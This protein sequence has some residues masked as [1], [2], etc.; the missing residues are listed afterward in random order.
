M[1]IPSP[2]HKP[3]LTIRRAGE[4][5][6]PDIVRIERA[7]FPTPWS[8]WALRAE[9]TDTRRHLYLVVTQGSTAISYVGG[10]WFL[11]TCHIS[12]LA[13]DETLRS[14][15]LGEGMMLVLLLHL[16]ENGARHATL[17]Y[18]P[19]NRAAARLYDKLGFTQIRIRVGYYHDTNEDA[20][21][22]AID[23]LDEV[24][25]QQELR[26]L[27]QQWRDRYGYEVEIIL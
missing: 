4:A 24:A 15:G 17:E 1:D 3:K 19:R 16:A 12:T 13:V 18:R 7:S 2:N 9:I 14:R 11:D 22:V 27:W 21:E 5:D 10:Q 20:V 6:L 23:D 8:E 25:R 26:Q